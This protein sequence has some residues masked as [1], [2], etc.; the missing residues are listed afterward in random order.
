MQLVR[1]VSA[2]HT[3]HE[4]MLCQVELDNIAQLYTIFFIK[5][6]AVLKQFA[7]IVLRRLFR[8]LIVK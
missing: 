7:I 2:L 4:I 5:Y 6:P 8:Y 3:R 1:K